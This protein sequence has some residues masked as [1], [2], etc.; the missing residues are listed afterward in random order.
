MMIAQDANLMPFF[1][2]ENV[3]VILVTVWKMV[4]VLLVISHA[5]NALEIMIPIVFLVIVMDNW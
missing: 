3:F 1:F 4:I 5:K 2:K